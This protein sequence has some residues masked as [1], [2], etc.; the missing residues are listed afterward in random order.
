MLLRVASTGTRP[1]PLAVSTDVRVIAFAFGVS[2]VT[3]LMVGALPA[4]RVSRVQLYDSFRSAGRVTGAQSHRVPLGRVLVTSQIALSLVLVVT[5]GV[6]V[7]TLRNLLEIDPGY[8]RERVVTARL[9]V[10]AAAYEYAQLPSLYDQLLGA[11]ASLPG[12]RSASLS[13][14]PLAGGGQRTSAFVVPG[15][16]LPPGE[17]SGQENYVTP[18]YFTTVGIPLVQGRAFTAA[19]KA[20]SRASRS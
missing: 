15:R 11:T 16:T 1:I 12:V 9:D 4:V 6:F 14:N 17:N 7:Q 3:G 8:E 2:L 18:D 13:L 20:G 19:D 5:A 10:R